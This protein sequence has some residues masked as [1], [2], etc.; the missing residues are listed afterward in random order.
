MDTEGFAGL[1]EHANHDNKIFLFSLLLSSFYIY[2]SVGNIDENALQS[3]SLIIELAKEIQI[4]TKGVETDPE[5]LAQYFPTFLWVV[6]D[7]ALRLIDTAGNPIT[8]K[9]YLEN[10]LQQQKGLND[11]IEARNR[12]RRLFKTF[13]KER[14]CC[15]MV[16]PL[17]DEKEL[18]KLDELSDDKLR[19]E[20]LEQMKNV[21]KRIF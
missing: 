20:F 6:R 17:E 5:E 10:A 8:S 19:S 21:K 16:R 18:Q 2:N 3:L 12:I 14:D 11:S 4:K 7:F 1:D 13:F 9:D 15:T